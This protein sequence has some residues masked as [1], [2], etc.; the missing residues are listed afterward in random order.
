[1]ASKSI[2]ILVNEFPAPASSSVVAAVSAARVGMTIETFE[3]ELDDCLGR[4]NLHLFDS[5][6]PC[7]PV[8]LLDLMQYMRKMP[9]PGEPLDL[10]DLKFLP[11][12]VKE[13][14][15]AARHAGFEG[16]EEQTDWS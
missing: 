5:S 6:R 12:W 13:D 7:A 14:W 9:S 8:L 4:F 10:I 2:Q 11:A 3:G 1:M 16:E 15:S